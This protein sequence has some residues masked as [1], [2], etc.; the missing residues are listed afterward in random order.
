MSFPVTI[1]LN[2]KAGM[3]IYE[4]TRQLIAVVVFDVE[5]DQLDFIFPDNVDKEEGAAILRKFHCL[6]SKNVRDL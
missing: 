4:G 3:G 6:P 1:Y 2:G 5:A